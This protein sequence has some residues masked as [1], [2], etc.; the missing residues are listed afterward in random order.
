MQL[1]KKKIKLIIAIIIL[2]IAFA[3]LVYAVSDY[4]RVNVSETDYINEHSN[5]KKVNNSGSGDIFVPTKT[6]G[7]WSSFYDNPPSGVS[8]ENVT[9]CEGSGSD[10]AT[11]GT[12]SCSGYYTPCGSND[13]CYCDDITS[14]R[15]VDYETCKDSS[16]CTSDCPAGSVQVNC[17]A[18]WD[19]A[20]ESCSGTTSGS[21]VDYGSSTS[22]GSCP[23]VYSWNG[24][25]YIFDSEGITA[26]GLIPENEGKQPSRLLNLKS[27][28][29]IFKIRVTEE[30]EE[31]SHIDSVEL[32]KVTHPE[33]VEVYPG[34]KEESIK[35]Y[36]KILGV[37]VPLS[38]FMF[39]KN[40]GDSITKQFFEREDVS[41][42]FTLYTLKNQI[43]PL[44]VTE[45]GK[46]IKELMKIDDSFWNENFEGLDL[47]DEDNDGFVDII[48][49]SEFIRSVEFVY[50]RGKSDKAKLRIRIK[51]T[52][53]MSFVASH[54]IE[55]SRRLG[56]YDAKEYL[57][58]A[59]RDSA[60]DISVWNGEKWTDSSY[61]NLYPREF[62]TDI[63]VPL[64][65]A[66]IN[67]QNLRVRIQVSHGL[68]ELDGAYIDYSENELITIERI[69]LDRATMNNQCDVIDTLSESD[70][71]GIS[72]E[73]GDYVNLEFKGEQDNATFF[74]NMKGYYEPIDFSEEKMITDKE[75]IERI[76]DEPAFGKRYWKLK[77]LETLG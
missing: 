53:Y 75:I 33:N 12:I 30:L 73:K 74:L 11:C 72:I 58:N 56:I 65:L 15:C 43:E 13:C 5:C 50:P 62:A 23:Y 69:S 20:I 48:D 36:P 1:N 76:Y 55:S 64:D 39:F 47:S 22:S 8:A 28:N 31:I 70:D 16:Y 19:L 42:I 60:Y 63:V 4:Y 49:P 37:D 57:K 67:T 41:T 66:E 54:T 77:Y 44:N 34:Y 18:D 3:I 9:C 45:D 14:N 27:D 2:S 29:G 68:L 59:P 61:V 52:D 46:E 7:E 32:L 51:E 35:G 17:P 71:K 25:G 6:S 10:D 24:T 38:T 21:C 40:R 26:F